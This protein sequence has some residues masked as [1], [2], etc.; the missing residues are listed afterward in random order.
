MLVFAYLCLLLFM[1]AFILYLLDLAHE[2]CPIKIKRFYFIV[3]IAMAVRYMVLIAA[4][5]FEKQKLIYQLRYVYNINIICIPLIGLSVFYIFLREQNR[6]FDYNY[7]FMFLMSLGY[8]ILCLVYKNKIVID[9][10][11]GFIVSFKEM[12]TPSLIYLIIMASITVLSLILM[13]KPF[14]NSWGMRMLMA[15]SMVVVIEFIIFMGG[16]RIFPY[17]IIGEAVMLIA[18]LKSILTFK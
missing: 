1:I 10:D 16:K 8:I 15:A 12:L 6:S 11:F 14:A 13:D 9:N 17:P 4:V 2:R 5:L 7:T 3:L 18:A